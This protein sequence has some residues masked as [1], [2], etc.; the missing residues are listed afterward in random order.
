MG[1]YLLNGLTIYN[2][3]DNCLSLESI[4]GTY[5]VNQSIGEDRNFV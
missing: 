1:L 4:D 5:H 2:Y 3:T